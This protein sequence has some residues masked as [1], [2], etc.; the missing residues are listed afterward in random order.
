MIIIKTS[1]N[2]MG[3]YKEKNCQESYLPKTNQSKLFLKIIYFGGRGN[4][5]GERESSSTLPAEH[6]G[7]RRALSQDPEITT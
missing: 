6:R 7:Q 1:E 3:K 2:R 5:R 4:R